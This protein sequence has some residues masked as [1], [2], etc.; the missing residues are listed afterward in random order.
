MDNFIISDFREHISKK[1]CWA[2]NV[3]PIYMSDLLGL[4]K[5]MSVIEISN[6][7]TPALL[8]SIDEIIVNAIDHCK[9]TEH[10][11]K[12]VTK[13]QV[14]YENGSISVYNNGLGIPITKHIGTGLY[15]IECAFSKFLAG[16]N[17]EKPTDSIKGGI[18]GLGAKIANIHSNLFIVET[19]SKK[20]KYIQVFKNRL[21]VI[22][23]PI[24]TPCNES[25][26][27]LI[28]FE[29][30]Y[31][32]LGYVSNFDNLKLDID[33]WLRLRMHQTATYLGDKVDVFYNNDK[34]T[35]T[36]ITLFSKLFTNDNII[37]NSCKSTN[38]Y[39]LHIAVIPEKV[40]RKSHFQNMSI[41]NGVISNK[42]SHFNYFKKIIKDYLDGKISKLKSSVE[43]KNVYSNMKLLI[44]GCIPGIDWSGQNKTEL[45]VSIKVLETYKISPSFL[46]SISNLLIGNI[47]TDSTSKDAKVE[48]DKYI[49]AKNISNSKLRKQCMLLAAEGD[50]AITLLRTGLTQKSNKMIPTTQFGP[51][52]NWLGII[53]LQGVVINAAKEITECETNL[54]S[55]SVKSDKLKNNKRLNMLADAFGLKYDYTYE[56]EYELN[57]LNYGHLIICTDQDLDGTGKIASLVLVWIY[58]FWPKLLASKRICK[59]MTPIIRAYKNKGKN[60][61]PIEFYYENELDYMLDH[62]S[63]FIN[64]YRIKYYKGLATHDSSEATS[65]FNST[66]FN[67]IVYKYTLDDAAHELFKIY[68]GN[69]SSLRKKILITPVRHLTYLES[70]NLKKSQEIPIG[71]VQLDIDTKL[72]KNE[73]I[74]RQLPHAIDGLNPA[75]RKIL[76]AS[77]IRFGSDSK[78]IKIFQLGG[79]VADKMLY[80]HGDASLNKTIICMAQNFPGA[81]K[82]PYLTGIGQFGDR[83]GS[84]A[85]SPRYISVKLSNIVSYIFPSED[86]WSL[87]YVFEEGI[88][89]EPEYF[90]PILPMAVLESY[91]IV[92]EGWNHKTYGR[93]LQD[94]LKVVMDYIN[95]DRELH[96]IANNVSKKG[97]VSTIP[98]YLI[99]KYPIS[100]SGDIR[101]F[102]D[103]EYSFGYYEYESL[104]NVIHITELPIGVVTSTYIE[105][106]SKSC[107]KYIDRIDD[108]SSTNEIEIH[109]Y[110]KNNVYKYILDHY[111]NDVVDPIEDCFNIRA[112]LKPNLN[113]YSCDK[114]VVEF[115]N[116]YLADILYWLP[117]RRDMYKTR[118]IRKEIILR[119]L[120]LKEQAIIKYIDM[121][122]D[123]NVSS[124][125]D[126]EI[127]KK[128]LKHH[129]FPG[130]Q[131][132]LLVNPGY[133][134]NDKLESLILKDNEYDYILDLKERE[135]TKL[136]LQKRKNNLQKHLSEYDK[137]N[138]LLKEEPFAG[139]SLW[140]DEINLL[141]KHIN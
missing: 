68:F 21:A 124:I 48:H 83:H 125:E 43:K 118:L 132:G 23:K 117:V 16:T 38:G 107:E 13:I 92:T 119:L 115:K 51:S 106:I 50:S 30:A 62:D 20:Q 89:A 47:I 45:Q 18:N 54:G 72:Y 137:V 10:G 49:K 64:N 111:G 139:A 87:P 113:Y 133:T 70:I 114:R 85:G 37:S 102:L 27:T 69:D 136:A 86:R 52:F 5:D 122:N 99:Y 94:V 59:L 138:K 134:S 109:I 4:N 61:P 11:T 26:Y 97:D 131:V 17:I 110:L 116:I 77:I 32:E 101:M 33:N 44:C 81:R 100:I 67:K 90:I 40:K 96:T 60:E 58:T 82:Y 7:H 91:Q 78:E 22:E 53:S 130:I 39:S 28:K 105:H 93:N 65:M 98:M 103:S 129:N 120:I 95:G 9:G 1:G 128:V 135:L 8:K 14:T 41:I 112:S 73:A 31:V 55:I 6:Q 71:K 66:N 84:K 12:K 36:N 88:R 76:M 74:N 141:L 127:A 3:T 79:Y 57:T 108:Y 123:I 140:K 126:D 63:E 24:I 35:T 29:P 46:L 25:E 19:V 34:C 56:S 104:K 121:S 80:M 42:G 15:I 75:R 2:G